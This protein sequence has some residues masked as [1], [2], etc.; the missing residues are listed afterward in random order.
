MHSL[1]LN[2]NVFAFCKMSLPCS[3]YFMKKKKKMN[4]SNMSKF[5]LPTNVKTTSGSVQISAASLSHG[6]V[7][8]RM[9]VAISLMKT[10]HTAHLE[11]AA[12]DNSSAVMAVAFLRAGNV[13]LIM[14]VVTTLMSH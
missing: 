3:Y 9:T 13:M 12:R 5:Q 6:S 2:S 10:Q 14:T 7:T 8:V 1:N 11:P 4:C